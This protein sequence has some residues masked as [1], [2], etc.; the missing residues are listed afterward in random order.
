MLTGRRDET[1]LD[2]PGLGRGLGRGLDG[3]DHRPEQVA[4]P[5]RRPRMRVVL[6]QLQTNTGASCPPLR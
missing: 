3:P 1:V 6:G 2:Q 4:I 5:P